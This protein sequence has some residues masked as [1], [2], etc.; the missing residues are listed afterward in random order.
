MNR[1]P[2]DL[3][4][5]MDGMVSRLFSRMNRE[6]MAGPLH[7]YRYRIVF[8][9]GDDPREMQDDTVHRD[10]V[11]HEP[12]AEVH[13]IGDEVKVIAALPGITDDSLRLDVQ[14]D[15]L[16]IDAGDAEHHYRTSAALPPV[17]VASMQHSLRNGV[18][19]VTFRSP[20]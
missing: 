17:D 5:E 16:I 7:E 11:S 12:A 8:Q 1:D 9:D 19:E 13:S 4:E 6:F 14:G 20:A 10:P 2:M 3:F 15:N 18:L